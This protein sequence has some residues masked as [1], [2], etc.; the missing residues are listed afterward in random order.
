MTVVIACFKHGGSLD[1]VFKRCGMVDGLDGQLLL[2][3][4]ATPVLDLFVRLSV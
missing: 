3:V 1:D 2:M 4:G